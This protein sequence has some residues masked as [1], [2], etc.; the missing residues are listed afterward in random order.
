VGNILE[1]KSLNIASKNLKLNKVSF[2]ENIS[3]HFNIGCPL[4][5]KNNSAL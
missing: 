3:F 1:M 2:L 5:G 4:A